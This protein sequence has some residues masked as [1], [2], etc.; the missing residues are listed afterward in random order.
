M[1]L[2]IR[3]ATAEDYEQLCE[4][5][6]EIDTQHAK[7]EPGVYRYPS[8]VPA[9]SLEFLAPAFGEREAV[10]FVAEEPLHGHEDEARGSEDRGRA[11]DRNVRIVGL[12]HVLLRYAP[13]LPIL[14]PR[15]FAVVDAL[16]VR[17]THR[18]QGIGT[19]LMEEARRWATEKGA[20]DLELGVWEFNHEAVAFYES[21]G[22]TTSVR[23]MWIRLKEVPPRED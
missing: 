18:R 22:F 9:R 11:G 4:V 8:P 17:A 19:R 14:R 7:V 10:I 5:F 15:C 2:T 6:A 16:V 1:A 23:R 21:L 3:P 12:A 20:D 13:D